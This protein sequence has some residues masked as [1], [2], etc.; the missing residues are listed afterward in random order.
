M[1]LYRS[2][3]ESLA[4]VPGVKAVG[5]NTS[6]LY[7]GGRS[8]GA[9]ALPGVESKP[10]SPTSSFFNMITPGYFD[11]LGIPVKAG[12]DLNWRDWGSGKQVCLVNDALIARYLNGRNPVG[13]TLGRGMNNTADFEIV[14]VFGN[15]RYH[16][17]RGE[18]PPQTF[19]PLDTRIQFVTGV[20][21][22]A[23]FQG[24]PSPVMAQLRER[25]RQ[26]DANLVI[27]DM[28]TLDGQIDLRLANERMLSFLSAGFAVLAALLAVTGLYGVLA[29]VVTR[30]NREIGIRV[31]LGARRDQ[32]IGLVLREMTVVILAGIAAGL[33]A[34][35]YCGRF[36][37]TQLYGVQPFDLTVF[38]VAAA[39]LAA[40]S[41]VAA[42][43]PAWRASRLDPM[44]AL[45]PE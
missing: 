13:M 14:G 40:A 24:D 2:L 43:L 45:R 18:F 12:R 30:R 17:V 16:D 23:R 6:R 5:G 31:A 29:Y 34:G 36:V 21:V 32:V 37:E 38:A 35:V 19:F 33:A 42:F 44:T 41:L 26:V 39:A 3:F 7:T 28:R 15:A 10:E 22:Y 8:D 20:N 1:H 11:A 25:V 9:I 4:L 27:S